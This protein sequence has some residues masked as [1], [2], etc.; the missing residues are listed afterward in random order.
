MPGEDDR[1]AATMAKPRTDSDAF[2]GGLLAR[3]DGDVL[4]EGVRVLVRAV[5]EP[6]VT[7]LIGAIL[8]EQDLLMAFA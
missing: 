6:E 8:L 5:M 7:G 1:G 4:R 3:Q 2:V